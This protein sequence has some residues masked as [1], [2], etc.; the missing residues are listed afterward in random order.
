[1]VCD[2]GEGGGVY[3]DLDKIAGSLVDT[4]VHKEQIKEILKK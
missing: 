1:M 4:L 2:K 3:G